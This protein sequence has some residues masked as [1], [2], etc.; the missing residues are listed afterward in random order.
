MNEMD[1]RYN[2][3]NIAALLVALT[4]A[5]AIILAAGCASEEEPAKPAEEVAKAEEAEKMSMGAKPEE[6]AKLSDTPVAGKK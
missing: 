5:T 4:F 1:G 3:H 6:G 2:M